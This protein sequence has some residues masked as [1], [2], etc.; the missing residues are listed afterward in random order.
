L[1]TGRKVH[2]FCFSDKTDMCFGCVSKTS[3]LSSEEQENLLKHLEKLFH[4]AIKKSNPVIGENL[5]ILKDFCIKNFQPQ[6]I[7]RYEESA[8]DSYNGP[9][10]TGFIPLDRVELK[11]RADI[12]PGMYDENDFR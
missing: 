1:K 3:Q 9:F 2:G 8:I 6:S 4:D 10:I 12:Y 5:K 7:K 11:G